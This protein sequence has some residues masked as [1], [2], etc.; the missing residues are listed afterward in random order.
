M[1]TLGE[2]LGLFD[3]YYSEN[4]VIKVFDVKKVADDSN[5]L[6]D[7]TIGCVFGIVAGEAKAFLKPVYDEAEIVGIYI[8]DRQELRVLVDMHSENTEDVQ[9]D[10][11]NKRN[12]LTG[13]YER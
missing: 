8:G 7:D 1:V 13:R 6:A 3:N 10:L 5:C 11:I 9:A 4:S 12:D 2:F